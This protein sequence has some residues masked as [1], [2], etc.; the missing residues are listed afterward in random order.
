MR[1][2]NGGK[3][4]QKDKT[5]VLQDMAMR[6]EDLSNEQREE[7]GQSVVSQCNT[8]LREYFDEIWKDYVVIPLSDAGE[9]A[10]LYS[11]LLLFNS[12]MLNNGNVSLML[13]LIEEL[14]R[15]C[16]ETIMQ[17]TQL[18]SYQIQL[19]LVKQT[20]TQDGIQMCVKLQVK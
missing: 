4:M 19:Q 16:H 1:I 14:A 13:R 3:N 10:T 6:W 9:S 18:S 17:H 2:I 7:I 12:I 11:V 8:Y 20:I 15:A 5:I